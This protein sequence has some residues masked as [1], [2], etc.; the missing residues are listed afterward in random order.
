MAHEA[1]REVDDAQVR[2]DEVSL[3]ILRERLYTAVVSDVLDRQ[4]LL[5]QAMSARIRPLEPRMRLVGRAHTVLTA[6]IYQRPANPYEKEI[7]S[8]DSLKPGDVMVAATN[9]SE[10]TCLWGE[11]LST[12]ARARGAAGALIDGHTRDVARILEMEFPLFCTGFRPVDSSSRSIVVDYDCPVLCGGVMVSPGDVIFADI[13]GVVVIPQDRLEETVQAALEKVQAE[14][15]SRQMLEEGYL[16]RDVY[17]R[18]GV[19]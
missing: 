17:D 2:G 9:G 16:L 15:S 4:G 19:L 11:L 13:D 10:R 14:N 5:E 12:A 3:R 18:F 7:A 8:V 6:D 1:E